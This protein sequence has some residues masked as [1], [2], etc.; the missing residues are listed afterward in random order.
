ML[1][2]SLLSGSYRVRQ[3]HFSYSSYLCLNPSQGVAS[4]VGVILTCNYNL[5]G[6]LMASILRCWCKVDMAFLKIPHLVHEVSLLFRSLLHPPISHYR[7]IQDNWFYLL[8]S[9]YPR[10]QT[11]FEGFVFSYLVSYTT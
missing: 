3:I 4:Y 7:S 10:F 11:L 5:Q 1:L 2:R 9:T 6:C 8:H